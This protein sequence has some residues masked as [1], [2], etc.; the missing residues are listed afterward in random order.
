[1]EIELGNRTVLIILVVLMFALALGA[2]LFITNKLPSISIPFFPQPPPYAPPNQ[3]YINVS[4]ANASDGAQNVTKP[5][6]TEEEKAALISSTKSNPS[7]SSFTNKTKNYTT[8]FS[9]VPDGE[10]ANLS[11]TQPVLYKGVSGNVSLVRYEED[12]DKGVLC[13]MQGAQVVR[14]LTY[15]GV[16]MP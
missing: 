13:V 7:V 11:K 15:M 12:K 2:Y 9:R 3:T 16:K 1:M 10:L 14:C 4:G 5:E 6:F 8:N